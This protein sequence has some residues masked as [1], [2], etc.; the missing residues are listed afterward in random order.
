M[1]IRRVAASLIETPGRL[2]GAQKRNTQAQRRPQV[3]SAD[4]PEADSADQIP[5]GP[6]WAI[7]GAPQRT[8]TAAALM[9]AGDR[10]QVRPRNRMR[11]ADPVNRD[12]G[13]AREP[14]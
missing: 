4:L 10:A 2:V 12:H 11:G 8:R 14:I 9:A 3:S 6:R 7:A 5:Y 13:T 1:D